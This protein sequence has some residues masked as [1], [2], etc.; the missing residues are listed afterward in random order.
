MYVRTPPARLHSSCRGRLAASAIGPT[1][2]ALPTRSLQPLRDCRSVAAVLETAIQFEGGRAGR[3][4]IE[5]AVMNPALPTLL[6]Y[7]TL[8]P[9]ALGR[10]PDM[11]MRP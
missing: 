3:H 1:L 7:D 11:S 2:Q 8:L 9:R 10:S 6:S 4:G 5:E